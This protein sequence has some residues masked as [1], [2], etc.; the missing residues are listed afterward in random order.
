MVGPDF[1]AATTTSVPGASGLEVVAVSVLT[2]S[3]LNL[4]QPGTFTL[5][6][7][8]FDAV[9]TGPAT[10]DLALNAALGDENGDPLPAP[11]T[12]PA[13][14]AVAA[15]GIPTASQWALWLL[16]AMLALIGM[17]RAAVARSSR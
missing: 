15:V 3:E 11:V 1:G 2:P 8:T 10:F 14:V 16:A 6:T 7:A 4:M 13:V 17:R 12:V 5:F 9:G